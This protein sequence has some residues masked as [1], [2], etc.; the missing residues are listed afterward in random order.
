MV[1]HF[2]AGVGC[3]P[4]VAGCGH[5]LQPD[6][7]RCADGGRDQG[8]RAGHLLFQFAAESGIPFQMHQ[9]IEDQ[10]LP[11]IERMQTEY[12]NAKVIWAHLSQMR[13]QSRNTRYGP[14]YMRKLIER[15]P[16]LYFDLHVGGPRHVYPTSGEY[17][18]KYWDRATGRLKPEWARLIADHPWRFMTA[19]DLNPFNMQSFA[20]KVG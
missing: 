4:V 20:G 15:H 19:L 8:R 18:G 17:P 2:A 5:R 6:A 12:P 9:E 1:R 10:Y 16:N 3:E 7:R 11:V 14:D 13:L